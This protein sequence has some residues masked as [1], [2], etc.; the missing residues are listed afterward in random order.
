MSNPRV[1]LEAVRALHELIGTRETKRIVI[2]AKMGNGAGVVPVPN[3]PNYVYVRL[4]GDDN[5]VQP[6][7]NLS[8]SP[9]NNIA[10]E[11]EEVRGAHGAFRYVVI[12]LLP[13][14][15]AAGGPG[16]G[17]WWLTV[18]DASGGVI[19]I[20]A[21]KLKFPD[22]HV[23]DN[24]S[25]VVSIDF[26][27]LGHT[28]EDEGVALATRSKLNFVGSGVT[29]TDDLANDASKVTIPIWE[30][31]TNGDPDFPELIFLDGDVVM[32]AV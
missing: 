30:P 18:Q 17:S 26:A 21:T 15:A 19:V 13:A 16:T 4:F 8:V 31:M 27:G 2:P 29:A 9:A 23:T 32:S 22:G 25:G 24:G 1:H 10:V 12:G 7:L 5:R 6:A 14:I 3:N 20:P 28:V 11:V